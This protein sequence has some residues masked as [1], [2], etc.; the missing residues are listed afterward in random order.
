MIARAPKYASR[1][2]RKGPWTT[3]HRCGFICSQSTLRFQYYFGGTA[4]PQKTSTL[5]CPRCLD[6][7]DWQNKLLVIPP[8]PPVFYNLNPEP[9]QVDATNW[10]STFDG[11]RIVT[12]DGEPVT[13]DIP[14]AQ[15]SGMECQITWTARQVGIGASLATTAFLDLFNGNPAGSG[16]SVLAEIS[17][18]AVRPNL[19]SQLGITS[20]QAI[21]V[22]AISL[23]TA[24]DDANVSH[25][26]FYDAA[27][28]GTRLVSGPVSVSPAVQKGFVVKFEST[29]LNISLV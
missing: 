16:Y 2:A 3:C 18:T 13:T 8:D 14:A 29:A 5:V 27:S 7:L 25:A 1:D 28:A 20:I 12:M 26:A 9:Y 4:V 17:G 22:D 6:G 24:I 23:F 15:E 19:A 10:L 11:D 21:N